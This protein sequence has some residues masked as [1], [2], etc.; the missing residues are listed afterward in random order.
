V[1]SGD[2][3]SKRRLI[4]RKQA[5]YNR[6]V[7]CIADLWSHMGLDVDTD[8]LGAELSRQAAD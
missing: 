8:A 2:E 3:I 6:V 1:V 7:A 5:F 4:T